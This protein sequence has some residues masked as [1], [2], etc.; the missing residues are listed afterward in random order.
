MPTIS[1][2]KNFSSVTFSEPVDEAKA[3]GNTNPDET[4]TV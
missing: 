4:E 2:D 3:L 1:Y